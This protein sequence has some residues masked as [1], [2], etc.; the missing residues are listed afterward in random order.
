MRKG[1]TVGLLCGGLLLSGCTQAVSVLGEPSPYDGRWVGR[2]NLS[3]GER[4]CLR[5]EPL[6]ATVKNGVL[7]GLT[8]HSRGQMKLSGRI[9]DDGALH[10]GNVK[11]YRVDPDTDLTGAFTE[12]K[13]KGRWKTGNCQGQWNLRRVSTQVE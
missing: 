1:L 7:T 13:A 4:S 12:N 11:L 9:G 8:R 6:Q 10:S 2:I 5:R 3:Y